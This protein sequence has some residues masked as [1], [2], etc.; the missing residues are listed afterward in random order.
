MTTP[1]FKEHPADRARR[2]NLGKPHI[3]W[4]KY[5]TGWLWYGKPHDTKDTWLVEFCNAQDRRWTPVLKGRG[6][7]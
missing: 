1:K 6:R 3:G 5:V 4:S 2:L 7:R